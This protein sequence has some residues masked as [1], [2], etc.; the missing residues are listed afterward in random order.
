MRKRASVGSGASNTSTGKNASHHP[1]VLS[2]LGSFSSEAIWD[3]IAAAMVTVT[4]G[5]T[6]AKKKQTQRKEK[7]TRIKKS[8]GRQGR[9]EGRSVAAVFAAEETLHN[10]KC[11][12]LAILNQNQ[13]SF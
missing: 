7:G 9:E 11:S 12:I 3:G 10:F 5:L 2:P 1:R 8:Q 4:M 13:T 6:A